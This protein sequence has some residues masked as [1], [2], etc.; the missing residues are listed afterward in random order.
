MSFR[1]VMSYDAKHVVCNPEE[2][3]ELVAYASAG[4]SIALTDVPAKFGAK[5]LNDPEGA[6]AADRV[7]VTI[8]RTSLALTEG[9]AEF[10]PE[11]GD[12]LTRASGETVEVDEAE[13][14]GGH[15]ALQVV[16]N[17]RPVP[18]GFGR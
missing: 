1:D 16:A 9:G 8:A 10:E 14:V 5:S 3:G 11:Q 2:L 6:V 17:H 18:R 7:P 15:W 13:L 4:R 12:V